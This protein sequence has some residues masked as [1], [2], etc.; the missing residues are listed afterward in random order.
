MGRFRIKRSIYLHGLSRVH[1]MR[2]RSTGHLLGRV[3]FWAETQDVVPELVEAFLVSA[4]IL[5]KD[6]RDGSE[7]WDCSG[8]EEG[9]ATSEPE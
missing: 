2:D 5:T 6:W 7:D 3:V 1:E 4:E 8:K 9:H